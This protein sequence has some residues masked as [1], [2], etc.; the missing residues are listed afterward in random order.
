MSPDSLN[1]RSPRDYRRRASVIVAYGLSGVI[2]GGAGLIRP[3]LLGTSSVGTALD[4]PVAKAWLAAYALG[5]LLAACGVMSLRPEVET[6]GLYLLLAAALINAVAIYAVRGPIAGG[7]TSSGILLAAWVIHRRIGDL[8][9][10]AR[11][12][13]RRRDGPFPGPDRRAP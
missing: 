13:R 4:S 12:D 2:I 11:S 9:E 6:C 5:G 10:A 1:P 7:V 3:A 8:H